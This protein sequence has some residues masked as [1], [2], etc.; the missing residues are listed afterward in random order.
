M[1]RYPSVNIH[2]VAQHFHQ[3]SVSHLADL[4]LLAVSHV[5]LEDVQ[6][7]LRL[8][9][10]GRISVKIDGDDGF[11]ECKDASIVFKLITS[12]TKSTY[13]GISHFA[14]F[15]DLLSKVVYP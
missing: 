4:D 6:G 15:P 2:P 7:D 1:S 10:L 5:V 13:N 3:V 9:A 14:F 12:S 11:T 8:S